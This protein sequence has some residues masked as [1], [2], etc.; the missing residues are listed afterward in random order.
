MSPLFG[1]IRL[2]LLPLLAVAMMGSE[3]TVEPDY[4]PTQED[5]RHN[6]SYLGFQRDWHRRW[7]NSAEQLV[8]RWTPDHSRVVF[9]HAG[10]IY[11]VDREGSSLHSLS[12]SYEPGTSR[13]PTSE[14]DFSPSVSPDGTRVAFTTLRYATGN[15]EEHT[16]EIATQNIDGTDRRKLTSNNR[17]DVSPAWS[18]AGGL[19][20]FVT[21]TEQ[22][23][24]IFTVTEDGSVQRSLA[25]MVE[26]RVEAPRWSPD[27]QFIAF[28]AKERADLVEQNRVIEGI[29]SGMP[30]REVLYI[31]A[32][33][34]SKR[35][36]VRISQ[37]RNGPSPPEMPLGERH[38]PEERITTFRWSPDGRHIALLANYRGYA[39]GI[40][41]VRSDG[42][43]LHRIVDMAEVAQEVG[44]VSNY[45]NV[46]GLAWPSDGSRILFEMAGTTFEPDIVRTT[47]THETHLDEPGLRT[48]HRVAGE[49]LYLE[50]PDIMVR[51]THYQ[52]VPHNR[53]RRSD[54]GKSSPPQRLARYTNPLVNGRKEQKG[55][56][57]SAVVWGGESQKVLAKIVDGRMTAG[58]GRWHTY[59]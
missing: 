59:R 56:V 22:G 31:V 25:P 49:E 41:I 37:S 7:E 15:L 20:A 45:F 5:I 33:D 51:D 57:L 30:H 19:I 52:R 1:V 3:C 17:D 44:Y 32:A 8:P 46:K 40:Y 28:L 55:W 38:S 48:M 43:N 11:A 6:R 47:T 34:G 53:I 27:G 35:A 2:G 26:A 16:Y 58:E 21:S 23:R 4:E 10:R 29:E 54:S 36:R 12:G 18:P 42:T 50:W 13:M 39:P 9:G 14:L 24:R